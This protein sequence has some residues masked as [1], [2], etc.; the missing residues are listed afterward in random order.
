MYGIFKIFSVIF[1]LFRI[2]VVTFFKAIVV[3]TISTIIIIILLYK[4][5]KPPVIDNLKI[6]MKNYMDIMIESEIQKLTTGTTDSI[7]IGTPEEIINSEINQYLTDQIDSNNGYIYE[8]EYYKIQDV[9]V[10]FNKNHIDVM[11]SVHLDAQVM[12]Y[13]TRLKLRFEV[14]ETQLG[15]ISLKLSS[16]KLGNIPLRWAVVLST[17]FFDV[18][19]LLNEVLTDFGV[20]DKNRLELKIDLTKLLDKDA[21]FISALLQFAKENELLQIGVVPQGDKYLLGSKINIEKL[22]LE[23]IPATLTDEQ[24]IQNQDELE[25]LIENR[26]VA[27]LFTKGNQIDFS[28]QD[29]QKIIDFTVMGEIETTDNYIFKGEVFENYE[30]YLFHPYTTVTDQLILNIPIKIGKGYNFFKSNIQFELS[31][32]PREN[33]L[34]LIVE[35]TYIQNMPVNKEVINMLI[36]SFESD[37]TTLLNEAIVIENFFEPFIENE[38]TIQEIVM[39]EGKMIF[40]FNG[41]NVNDMLTEIIDTIDIPEIN[42]IIKDI[43]DNIDNEENLLEMSDELVHNFNNLNDSDQEKI[44]DVVKEYIDTIPEFGK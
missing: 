1:N 33:D 40:I 18:E 34:I 14:E 23:E 37:L 44:M 28:E 4:D 39:T 29:V 12:T 20:F 22:R 17:E 15:V 5:E 30:L 13:K 41:L 26:I 27:N 2:I 6:D 38:I 31:L 21:E 8:N 9:W 3:I 35:N 42:Y 36:D 25:N 10:E 24:K 43:M 32:K 19:E 7:S 16:M 11:L